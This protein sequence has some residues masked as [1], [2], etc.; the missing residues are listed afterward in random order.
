MRVRNHCLRRHRFVALGLKGRSLCQDTYRIDT[1]RGVS[2][3]PLRLS[4][5]RGRNVSSGQSEATLRLLEETCGLKRELEAIQ[6]GT[7]CLVEL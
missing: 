1:P 3:P 2:P 6:K 4:L 5:S 7:R